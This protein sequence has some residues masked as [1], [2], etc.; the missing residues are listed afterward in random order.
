MIEPP[1]FEE[2]IRILSDLHF[3]HPASIIEHP[4]QLTPLFREAK[5][6][7]FNGD[8]VELRYL[9]GRR[10]GM[11]NS[12]LMREAC[13]AAGAHPVF[14][15][16][17]HDPILSDI[18][19]LDLVDG[20]VLVTHGDLLFHDISPWSHDSVTIG[21]AHTRELAGMGEDAFLDFEK[22]LSA[23]KRAA[24]SIELHRTRMR[25]DSL[26]FIRTVLRECWPPWRP[27]QVFHSWAVTPA[28]AEALARVFRPRARFILIGHTHFSGCWRRGPRVVINTG[29]FLPLSGRMAIDVQGGTLTVRPILIER[30]VFKAGAPMMQFAATRLRPGEG[31]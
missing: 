5:T 23:S 13:E 24:L 31:Y 1:Q 3:G 27:F 7:V 4:E 22:R 12:V 21:A 19:H 18:S 11:R 10:I 9:R 15:N 26:T 25:R 8:T 14:I 2:P 17:N 28:R 6:V 29:S 16:G 30:G 20:A